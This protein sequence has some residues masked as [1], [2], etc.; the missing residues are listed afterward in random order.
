MNQVLPALLAEAASSESSGASIVPIVLLFTIGPIAVLLVTRFIDSLHLALGFGATAAAADAR[1]V[2]PVFEYDHTVGLSITGGHVYRGAAVP[3]LE[4]KY[5]YADY[6]S[7]KLFALSLD[8][9]TGRAKSNHLIES[10]KMP[11]I[12][13]GADAAGESYFLIVTGDGQGIYRFTAK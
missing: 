11:V 6:V 10:P 13:F 2:E 8:E 7:G 12:S 3:A 1:L 5:L 4:G 9:A